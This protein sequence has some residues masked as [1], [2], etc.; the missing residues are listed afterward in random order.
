[1]EDILEPPNW[2]DLAQCIGT[3]QLVFFPESAG[4]NKGQAQENPKIVLENIAKS[5]CRVCVVSD[6][7][8]EYALE[9]NQSNGI[10]GGKTPDERRKIRRREQA[11]ARQ[12][13]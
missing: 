6:K 10:W 7:C 13:S 5:I 1:M 4:R 3:D 11:R 2:Y 12:A 8:L 9:T